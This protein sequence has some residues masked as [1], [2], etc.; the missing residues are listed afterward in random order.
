MTL[1]SF[2]KR[3]VAGGP[4]GVQTLTPADIPKLTLRNHPQLDESDA[5]ALVLQSPGLSKWHPES[6]EFA[7]VTP[8]RHRRE[9]PYVHV[10]WSFRHEDAL[11]TSVVSSA[12]EAGAAGVILMDLHESRRPSF[13]A[14][15]QFKHL[16]T[17]VT[18]MLSQPYPFLGSMSSR[19]QQ[20]FRLDSR[21]PD[22]A[23]VVLDLDHAAFPWLWWNSSEE[24]TNYLRLPNVELWVGMAQ[25]EVVSYVGF[26]HFAGWSH[27]DRIA[28]R[29]DFQQ[30]GYGRE[31]LHFSVEKM[32]ERGARRVGLSTQGENQRSRRMYESVGFRETPE[33]HYGVY[34]VMF[35]EG[36]ERMKQEG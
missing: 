6:S 10:L 33:H 27:L 24:F 7:L 23:K 12:E 16:E 3:D 13:Y 26:T 34:G 17:I 4:P 15:N 11:M 22:L 32:V 21:R 28:V 25:G 19:N 18:Y 31:A 9:L 36:R 1:G 14:R 35:A 20:F 29:P 8:W 2:L 30:R 5:Q